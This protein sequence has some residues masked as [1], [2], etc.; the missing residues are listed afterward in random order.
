VSALIRCKIRQQKCSAKSA[1]TLVEPHGA[2]SPILH[3]YMA[4]IGKSLPLAAFITVFFK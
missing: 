4:I 1:N 3:P 2:D